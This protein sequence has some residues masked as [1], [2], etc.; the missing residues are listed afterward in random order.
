[1]CPHKEKNYLVQNGKRV[2]AEQLLVTRNLKLQTFMKKLQ[3]LE[4]F[5]KSYSEIRHFIRVSLCEINT[6]R[7]QAA[8]IYSVHRHC[9]L[10]LHT[11]NHFNKPIQFFG[12]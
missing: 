8:V 1:M 12:K 10:N 11:S 6:P 5:K 3:M 4:R 9:L 7:D 2:E